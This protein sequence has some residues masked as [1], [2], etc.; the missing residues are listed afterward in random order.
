MQ[1]L[2]IEKAH[3]VGH[4][5]GALIALQLALEG[6]GVVHSLSLLET[7][8]PSVMFA[9]PEVQAAMQK[10]MPQYQAGNKAGAL[11]AF[12]RGFLLPDY[13]EA[14][15]RAFGPQA[16]EQA[17]SAIDT[18]FQVEFPALQRWSFTREDAARIRQ[19]VLLILG[20]ASFQYWRQIHEEMQ[21]LLPQA[22]SFVLADSDHLLMVR[23][24]GEMAEALAGYFGRH[25]LKGGAA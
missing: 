5:S 6:P 9:A 20:G 3:I 7:A 12:M 8:L 18:L 4:S 11:D 23:K 2:G 22:A 10:A 1:R 25:P 19:P 16:F 13:G 21:K 24:P 15:S 17:L 14:V